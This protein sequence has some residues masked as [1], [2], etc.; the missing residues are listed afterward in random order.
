[1]ATHIRKLL[2]LLLLPG[3]ALAWLG[4]GEM[5]TMAAAARLVRTIPPLDAAAPRAVETATFALG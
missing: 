4:F 2:P 3:L 1:M 5:T